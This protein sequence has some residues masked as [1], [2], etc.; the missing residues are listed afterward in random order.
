MFALTMLISCRFSGLLPMDDLVE[1]AAGG[2]HT[3][4]RRASGEVLCWG[5]NN[6]G[7]LGNGKA[8]SSVLLPAIVDGLSS[9]LTLSLGAHH[10]CALQDGGRLVCWGNNESGQLGSGSR[11]PSHRPSPADTAIEIAQVELGSVHT[12]VRSADGG[13]WCVGALPQGPR[14]PSL[15]FEKVDGVEDAVELAVANTHACVRHTDSTVSCWGGNF[16][17]E[18]GDLTTTS[19][20]HAQRVTGLQGVAQIAVGMR[21]SC[22]RM[23]DGTVRCWGYGGQHAEER[24]QPVP[25]PGLSDVVQLEL[26]EYHGCARHTDGSISCWG[27]RFWGQLG[28]GRTGY[29]EDGYEPDPVRV[30]G[31]QDAV[32]LSVGFRHSCA[33]LADRTV[34]CWGENVGGGNAIYQLRPNPM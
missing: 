33:L 28:E 26:G 13:V 4:V 10:S 29:G 31:L 1:V 21:H 18:L 11:E 2:F 19:R 8:S 22:A 27:S 25:V 15:V 34:T 23:Q 9:G 24:T 7:Q 12:C 3:C 14:Q 30:S 32:Q 6:K 20:R 16:R 17:G 5:M